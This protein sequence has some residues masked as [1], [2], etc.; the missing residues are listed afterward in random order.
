MAPASN[1]LPSIRLTSLFL[2]FVGFWVATTA[3]EQWILDFALSYTVIAVIWG[4]GV[5]MMDAYYSIGDFN[6]FAY[7]LT[8]VM[9]LLM[10]LFKVVIFGIKRQKMV[11]LIKYSKKNFWEADYD[12]IGKK[13]LND[14]EKECFV[15]VCAFTVFALG[16]VISYTITPIIDNRGR[17][18]TDRNLPF[19]IWIDVPATT[20]PY[21]E[22]IFVIQTLS[23]FHVGIIYFCF[24]N[25]LCI[26]NV[27]VAGQFRIL[28]SR[29][30]IAVCDVGKEHKTNGTANLTANEKS[31][32]D[33]YHSLQTIK[34]CIRQHQGLISFVEEMESTYSL[35]ILGQVLVLSALTCLVAYQAFLVSGPF[36]RRI[37]FITHCSGTFTQL[38]MFTLTCHKLW[39]ASVEVNDAAFY[40]GWHLLNSDNFPAVSLKRDILLMMMRAQRP[41]CLTAFGFFPVSLET[42]MKINSTAIS[43]LTLLRQSAGDN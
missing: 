20:T 39:D 21:F 43:Y 32:F 7:A 22:I 26:F 36:L 8:N 40:S 6:R 31:L 1:K 10:V 3:R 19:N 16:T 24:D 13:V 17:N 9:T 37:I 34:T 33:P 35:C 11:E 14:C 18:E 23:S 42:F 15:F 4:T 2:R 27:H 38:F 25:L 29:L 41:C 5:I 28:N 30:A 12:D